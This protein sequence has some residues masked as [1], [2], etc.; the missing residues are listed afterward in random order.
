M[1]VIIK[2]TLIWN[3]W[4][5][6][7][8]IQTLSNF[9]CCHILLLVRN[10]NWEEALE[11]PVSMLIFPPHKYTIYTLYRE[12]YMIGQN[13]DVNILCIY[14][15]G[16]FPKKWFLKLYLLSSVN[17]SRDQTFGLSFYKIWCVSQVPSFHISSLM[18][19]NINYY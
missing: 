15:F 1:S 7:K 9:Y 10:L 2:Q 16:I 4:K 5:N 18:I 17:F 3:G 11:L 19:Y 13:T 8:D 6:F 14:R 12:H